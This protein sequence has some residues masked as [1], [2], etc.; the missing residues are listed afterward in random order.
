MAFCITW[1]IPMCC[2]FPS[3]MNNDQTTTTSDQND[4]ADEATTNTPQINNVLS[5]LNLSAAS[6][7]P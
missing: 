2:E 4:D 3:H 1:G 6:A 7:Y 5:S